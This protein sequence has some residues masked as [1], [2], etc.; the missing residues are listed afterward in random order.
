MPCSSYIAPHLVPSRQFL[1]QFAYGVCAHLCHIDV[2]DDPISL[3][4]LGFDFTEILPDA[5][6][7]PF[8]AVAD[9]STALN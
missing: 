6:G 4:D 8:I 5:F 7:T 9:P 1:S 3:V 2:G